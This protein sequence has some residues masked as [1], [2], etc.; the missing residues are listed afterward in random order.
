[1]L[2]KSCFAPLAVETAET[3]GLVSSVSTRWKGFKSSSRRRALPSRPC[4][5]QLLHVDL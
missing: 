4:G 2:F 1:M 5:Q 3:L